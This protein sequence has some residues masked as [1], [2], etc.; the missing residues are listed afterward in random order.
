[1][2]GHRVVLIPLQSHSSSGTSFAG[3]IDFMSR[4]NGTIWFDQIQMGVA[5]F[6]FQQEE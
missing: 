2:P 3:R 6:Q 4:Y 1:M 5:W